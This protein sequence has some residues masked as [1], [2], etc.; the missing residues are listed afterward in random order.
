MDGFAKIGDIY[1]ISNLYEN[2]LKEGIVA[3]RGKRPVG[4][5]LNS[6]NLWIVDWSIWTSRRC[7]LHGTIFRENDLRWTWS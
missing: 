7:D 5:T 2:S 1:N 6:R 4:V 3:D